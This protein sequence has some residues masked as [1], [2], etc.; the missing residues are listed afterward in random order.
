MEIIKSFFLK[1]YSFHIQIVYATDTGPKMIYSNWVE[2]HLEHTVPGYLRNVIVKIV[3]SK[4]QTIRECIQ[5]M[6]P[7][8]GRYDKKM[9]QHVNMRWSPLVRRTKIKRWS[10]GESFLFFFF[11]LYTHTLFIVMNSHEGINLNK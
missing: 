7:A 6:S 4:V 1:F 3:D 2:C 9:Y 11:Y 5:G 8:T 10:R